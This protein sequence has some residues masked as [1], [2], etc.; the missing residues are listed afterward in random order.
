MTSR[1]LG[2]TLAASVAA[3]LLGGC[4]R[5]PV[6]WQGATPETWPVL[7]AALAAERSRRPRSPWSAEVATTLREARSGRVVR[8]R[9]GLAVAPGRALRLILLGPAGLTTLDAWITPGRWRIAVPPLGIVRR[10]GE[11]SPPDLPVAFLRG[12]FFRPMEGTLFAARMEAEGP[13]WL[14]RD[15]GAVLEVRSR[16]CD[17]GEGLLAT[18]REHAHTESVDECRAGIEPRA[19][20][21]VAYEDETTGLGVDLALESVSSE[22]PVA[23][24]FVDPDTEASP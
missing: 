11:D 13:T 20:D 10:G 1:R 8:G 14:L 6:P 19:G 24:A 23:D 16:R 17:R 21:H 18:R 3:G 5:Q 2:A 9:G 22:P 12:W 15:G 4:V 7:R